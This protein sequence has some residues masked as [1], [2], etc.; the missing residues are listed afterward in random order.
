M[1]GVYPI[2]GPGF[3]RCLPDSRAEKVCGV[4]PMEN[5]RNHRLLW[6]TPA[7]AAERPEAERHARANLTTN[8]CGWLAYSLMS[9]SC[10]GGMRG[11]DGETTSPPVTVW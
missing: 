8:T 10:A 5:S 6:K 11:G 2:V 9:R 3:V 7:E 1:C 4:Y